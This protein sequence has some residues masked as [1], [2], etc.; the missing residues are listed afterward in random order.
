MKYLTPTHARTARF[1]HLPK[2]HKP[3]NPGRPIVS[4]CGAP[5]ERISEFV[6]HHLQPLVKLS[7]SYLKDTKDF[8]QKLSQLGPL[9]PGCILLTMDVSS[10]Y[11]NIPHNE[12]MEA[13]RKALNSR[14]SQTPPT[15]YLMEMIE[16]I[17]TLNNFT[18]DGEHYLQT[19]GTAMGT[20]MAP[21]YA[22]IFMTDLEER[23]LAS[24]TARPMVWWRFID[25]IFTIWKDGIETLRL[26][27]NE[28]NQ[29]HHTIKFTAECSV[30][31]VFFFL[32]KMFL[33]C[34]QYKQR[35]HE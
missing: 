33:Q 4:S 10:L 23:M 16:Q 6:D 9:P 3:G 13:C 31:R 12:G 29:F 30:E 14:L 34:K 5:T 21:S 17:L 1:Y 25:D 27:L 7:P 2:I 18:F 35:M 22:N 11:T 26:F 19:Q 20:K 15:H 32:S 28:S 24:T 8:L